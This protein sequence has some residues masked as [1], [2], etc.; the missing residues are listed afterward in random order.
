MPDPRQ[1]LG[2][3][4]EDACAAWLTACGWRI[5]ARRYRP[6]SPTGGEVDLVATDPEGCLVGVEVRARSTHRSGLA[7]TTVDA[8]R[9]ARIGRSLA[10][11]A[12][13]ENVRH[14]GL[15]VDL[16]TLE[17]EG[18]DDGRWRLRRVAGLEA[19]RPIS[20]RRFARGP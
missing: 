3:R 2:R 19:D 11:Y 7:A 18:V 5:H 4:A 12:S 1:D 10:S 16:V 17:R 6:N 15:R 9:V 13:T 8:R 20:G 14:A